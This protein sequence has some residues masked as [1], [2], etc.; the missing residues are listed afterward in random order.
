[1]LQTL[2]H[3][4]LLIHD[5]SALIW[6]DLLQN[7]VL[8]LTKIYY[9]L[10]NLFRIKFLWKF[11][12]RTLVHIPFR[13]ATIWI[14]D[15][16]LPFSYILCYQFI[17]WTL[18]NKIVLYWSP[19]TFAF[20]CSATIHK[21]KHNILADKRPYCLHRYGLTP[22]QSLQLISLS[23]VENVNFPAWSVV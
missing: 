5:W 8:G 9:R 14:S 23:Y 15:M 13:S 10:H 11:S 6:H 20:L 19:I 7:R 1:M 3:C 12:N 2:R 18:Y 22:N 17:K 4:K 21:L 16:Y